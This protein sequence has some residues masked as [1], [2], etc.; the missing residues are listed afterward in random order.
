MLQDRLNDAAIALS[1]VLNDA[2]IKFGIFG[3]YAI[4]VLGGQRESKD[5][6][7]CC[8]PVQGSS[9]R[10]LRSKKWI[11]CITSDARGLRCLL[12]V[13]QAKSGHC[14]TGGNLL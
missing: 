14:S 13:Q 4:A 3:G 1:R 11:C 8:C 10:A 12:V 5:I 6:D 7:L 9:H 2:G